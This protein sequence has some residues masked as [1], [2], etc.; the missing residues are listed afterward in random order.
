MRQP[1]VSYGRLSVRKKMVFADADTDSP[2]YRRVKRVRVEVYIYIYNYIY[3]YKKIINTLSLSWIRLGKLDCQRQRFLM[4]VAL[5][6]QGRTPCLLLD[7]AVVIFL[8]RLHG[9]RVG[10]SVAEGQGTDAHQSLG[11][12][13]FLHQLLAFLAGKHRVLTVYPA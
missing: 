2:I 12:V 9:V 3:K 1:C 6:T 5:Q 10:R 7:D 13:P 11:Q 4:C 8:A